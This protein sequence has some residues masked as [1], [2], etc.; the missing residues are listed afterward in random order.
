MNKLKNPLVLGVQTEP[1]QQ[2]LSIEQMLKRTGQNTGNMLFSASTSSLFDDGVSTNYALA[3]SNLFK[4]RDCIVIAAANW[5]NPN[6][7]FGHIAEKLEA[8][9]L[10]IIA[11]GLGAQSGVEKRIPKL[12]PGTQR[13]V[14]LLAE[15]SPLIS[16]R[17]T[18][19]C[20]VLEHYGAENA[21]AT[22]CP[23]LLMNGKQ[24]PTFRPKPQE[25]T[26]SESD[27]SVHGTRHH[28]HNTDPFQLHLYREAISNKYDLLL[29][30]E[31]ADFYYALD[32]LGDAEITK[33]ASPLLA[34]VYQ[35]SQ[36]EF[37]EYLKRHGKVFF[38]L[39]E[40]IEYNATKKF[41][42]GSRIHGTIAGILAGTPSLLIA[43]DS[44]TVEL[45]VAMGIPYIMKD[46]VP[47]DRPLDLET[48]YNTA[49][50]HDFSEKHRQYW[51]GFKDFFDRCGLQTNLYSEPCE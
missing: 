4:G 19:S 51:D 13:L 3:G 17:G 20:E 18:F 12:K 44:R 27:V 9:N 36:P 2:S 50:A 40:W 34:E 25:S 46:S 37:Q 7:D 31:L 39:R 14:S 48:Y 21:I 35:A 11:L 6:A 5:L 49:M 1:A 47:T 23:S 41:I 45:A 30:S 26:L 22:G 24:P 33:K 38:G 29:Q 8:A 10:P 42:I 32:Q 16:A 15:R 43:H 28:F